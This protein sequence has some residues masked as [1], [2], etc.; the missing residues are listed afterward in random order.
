M[1]NHQL[2]STQINVGVKLAIARA[3][4]RHKES[5]ESIAIWQDGK[6]VILPP[7]QIPV[8]PIVQQ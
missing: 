6:V 4:Q 1:S 7:S 3:L 5:N 2:L 8:E